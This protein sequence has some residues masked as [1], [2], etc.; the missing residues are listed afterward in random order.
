MDTKILKFIQGKKVIGI[1]TGTTISK[2]INILPNTAVYVPSSISTTLQLSK[3]GLTIST[4][5]VHEQIDLYIDGTDYFDSNAN[6]IK[7]LGGALTKEKII[8]SASKQTVI[9]AQS[10]KYRQTFDGCFVPIE[11]IPMSLPRILSIISKRGLGYILR[12]DSRKIGPVM[13]ELGNCI[14]DVEYDKEFIDSCKNI[15]GVVEHGFFESNGFI[16]MVEKDNC[17]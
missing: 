7:G 16:L 10:Y 6:L 15:C 8:C 2:Y 11:V 5:L 17:E 9:I 1:G 13:T 12:E 3:N 14:V 4:A